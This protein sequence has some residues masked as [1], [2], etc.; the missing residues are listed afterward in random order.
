VK[1][2]FDHAT[3]NDGPDQAHGYAIVTS[4]KS[5]HG[6]GH[7]QGYPQGI[8]LRSKVKGDF[9]WFRD[10]DKTYLI[11]D[12]ALMPRLMPLGARQQHR[13]ADG[14]AGQEDGGQGKIMNAIGEE[15]NTAANVFS[16]QAEREGEKY[17]REMEQVAREQEK[18][19]RRMDRAARD[20]ASDTSPEKSRE[21]AQK[22]A[23]LQAEMAPLQKQMAVF[24]RDL[25]ARMSKLHEQDAPMKALQQKMAEASRPM[26]D[27]NVRM[28]ELNQKH[29][30]AVREAERALK[31]MML[32]VA[33]RQSR[34]CAVG[35]SVSS[36]RRRGPIEPTLSMDP[37]LRGDD[38]SPGIITGCKIFSII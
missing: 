38:G 34:A 28:G 13:R 14:R 37:R 12:P 36:P 19:A 11:Q 4:N 7:H 35:L 16:R 2:K 33:K 21:F 30:E 6:V 5:Y 24:Q 20:M 26:G 29:A 31:A 15:M 1:V 18:V 9:L 23:A 3:I 10:G 25:S 32:E 8:G 27:L 22:M 17:Q